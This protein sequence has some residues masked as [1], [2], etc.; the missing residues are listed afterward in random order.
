MALL[1]RQEMRQIP[2]LDDPGEARF[3]IVHVDVDKCQGCRMCTLICPSNVLEMFGNGPRKKARV[4]E[5]FTMCLAC[6]N[7]HAVCDSGAIGIVKTYDFAGR[8]KQLD[9]GA[10]T[11]PRIF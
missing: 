10:P 11:P 4:K 2:T 1:T 5:A 8:Y 9:R 7:C 3:G 6:D